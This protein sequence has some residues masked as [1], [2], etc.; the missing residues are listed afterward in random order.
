M[1]CADNEW[2]NGFIFF[3]G[4][5]R[6]YCR[7]KTSNLNG[8]AVTSTT[9]N[10]KTV[11]FRTTV[12]P[13]STRIYEE[14]TKRAFEWLSFG[15]SKN[16]FPN[17]DSIVLRVFDMCTA[18]DAGLSIASYNYA[19][20]FQYFLTQ[21]NT[22]VPILVQR[23]LVI[24]LVPLNREFR[25]NTGCNIDI[26]SNDNSIKIPS[27]NLNTDEIRNLPCPSSFTYSLEQFCTIMTEGF[28]PPS[29]AGPPTSHVGACSNRYRQLIETYP[30]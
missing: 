19:N 26:Y 25:R 9:A 6:K 18:V 13:P 4:P 30:R 17:T 14:V 15:P 29:F 21:F 12:N 28:Q 2:C 20:L 11:S 5:N 1:Y 16:W 22:Q 10:F 8:V 27:C 7:L 23:Q 24:N 3:D